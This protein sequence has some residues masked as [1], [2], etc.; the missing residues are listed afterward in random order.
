MLFMDFLLRL[1]YG[2]EQF[3]ISTRSGAILNYFLLTPGLIT[4]PENIPDRVARPARVHLG[5]A[6]ATR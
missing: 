5:I 3:E 6:Y 2:K 4:R 1:P